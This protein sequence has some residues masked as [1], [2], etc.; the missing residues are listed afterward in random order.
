MSTSRLSQSSIPL[1]LANLFGTITLGYGINAI[2][3][4]QNALEPFELNALAATA[5]KKLIEALMIIYGTRDIFIGLSF[6][7]AAYFGT[8]K[9]LGWT[10]IAFSAVAFV[11]GIVCKAYVSAG[12]WNHWGY[13]PVVAIVGSVLAG[14]LDKV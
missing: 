6:Y 13:A 7:S 2:M 3:R 5:D 11:D 4:P 1:F 10:L 9:A 14:V 12:E 8:R